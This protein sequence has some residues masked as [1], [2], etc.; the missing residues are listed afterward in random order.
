MY[1]YICKVFVYVYYNTYIYIYI[2]VYITHIIRKIS[3]GNWWFHHPDYML[4][5]IGSSMRHVLKRRSPCH[6]SCL[7]QELEDRW[8]WM[9][10]LHKE[11][12]LGFSPPARWWLLDFI[13]AALPPPLP[14]SPPRQSS[15]P[16]LFANLL[17]NP[18]RQLG[19]EVCTAG[20]HPPRS[21]RSIHC[22]TSTAKQNAE[23][24]SKKYGRI[25]AR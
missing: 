4:I 3:M 7:G 1:I 2:Y 20:P 15:S 5:S 11:Y 17:A 6:H 12:N 10:Y 25:F 18:L 22:W 16:I 9:D 21:D 13:R 24:D 23:I 19:I 8:P 14:P